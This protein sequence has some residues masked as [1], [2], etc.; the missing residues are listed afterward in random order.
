MRALDLGAMHDAALRAV[1]RIAAMHGRAVVPHHEV[2]QLPDMLVDEARLSDMRPQRF[3]YGIGLLARVAFDVGVATPAEV[4]RGAAVDRV[5]QNCGMPGARRCHRIVGR[6][7]AFAEIAA[8][9]VGAVVLDPAPFDLAPEVGRQSIACRL[10]AGE[11]GVA[12]GRRDFQRIEHRCVGR[13]VEIA[14]VGVPDGLAVTQR[15]DRIALGVEHVGDDVDV[16]IARWA[17]A[18][19]LLVGRRIEFAEAAAEGQQV[20]VAER[21]AAQQD[22]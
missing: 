16:G 5:T 2:A 6:R 15:A 18:A 12:A 21:L 22:H 17:D 4:E 7:H 1:E 13:H 9:I 11:P 19:T 14:H 20:V 8:G 10:H 3:E